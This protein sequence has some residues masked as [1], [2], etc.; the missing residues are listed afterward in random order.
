MAGKNQIACR[1]FANIPAEGDRT[2]TNR[3]QFRETAK[4]LP[5]LKKVFCGFAEQRLPG[6]GKPRSSIAAKPRGGVRRNSRGG[7]IDT[8]PQQLGNCRYSHSIVAGGFEEMSR[9]TRLT[10]RISLMIRLETRSSRS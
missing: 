3:S 5:S 9:A 8:L 7:G 6:R 1:R 10:S 2:L 4:T